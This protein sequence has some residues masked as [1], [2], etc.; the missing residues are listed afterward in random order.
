MP[1]SVIFEELFSANSTDF[2]LDQ[3]EE[4]IGA[5]GFTVSEL[6][7]EDH[8]VIAS[9][10]NS[11]VEGE[12]CVDKDEKQFQ[13]SARVD[14]EHYLPMTGDWEAIQKCLYELSNRI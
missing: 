14:D 13:I 7:V 5:Y 1:I 6:V 3:L 12:L 2:A 4:L 8:F 11:V 10:Y 9:F